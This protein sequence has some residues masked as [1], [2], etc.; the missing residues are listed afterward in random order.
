[1]LPS[2]DALPTYDVVVDSAL[3]TQSM[4]AASL[5]GGGSGQSMGGAPAKIAGAP[6]LPVLGNGAFER[7]LEMAVDQMDGPC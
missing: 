2:Y 1:M 6:P 4:G 7:R 3:E 5:V